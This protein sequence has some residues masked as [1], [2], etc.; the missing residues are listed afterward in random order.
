[1]DRVM[2]RVYNDTIPPICAQDAEVISHIIARQAQLYCQKPADPSPFISTAKHDLVSFM[3]LSDKSYQSVYEYRVKAFQKWRGP[4]G[5]R[6]DKPVFNAVLD[7][8]YTHPTHCSTLPELSSKV[9]MALRWLLAPAR[10]WVESKIKCDGTLSKSDIE[11]ADYLLHPKKHSNPGFRSFSS[12]LRV[13]P[14]IV[15]TAMKGAAISRDHGFMYHP[16]I[17]W[18]R[19]QRQKQRPIFGDSLDNLAW[20]Y[21]DLSWLMFD[22]AKLTKPIAYYPEINIMQEMQ[23]LMS[24]FQHLMSIEGDYEQMDSYTCIDTVLWAYDNICDALDIPRSLRLDG[25]RCLIAYF[26]MPL[27]TGGKKPSVLM[28]EHNLLSGVY[29]TNGMESYINIIHQ[30]L[31]L[32]QI[33]EYRGTS[34]FDLVANSRFWV[35]GDDSMLILPFDDLDHTFAREAFVNIASLI[36][37]VANVSKQR[38]STEAAQFCRFTY[39]LTVE[40]LAHHRQWN[41]MKYPIYIIDMAVNSAAYPESGPL[42]F[43]G[44]LAEE[45]PLLS[46]LDNAVGDPMYEKIVDI[47][48]SD[49]DIRQFLLQ[50]KKLQ[51]SGCRVSSWKESVYGADQWDY[52]S[53][54]TFQYL[55]EK[56]K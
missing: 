15:E 1:M 3:T 49:L 12:K 13:D 35:K 32:E 23:K 54:P 30:L 56:L 52:R 6:C 43:A 36:G 29:V 31:L 16:A 47:L 14:T 46:R 18:Y 24:K 20:G 17:V 48:F 50:V 37:E 51:H 45:L 42:Y 28:A 19:D 38:V 8:F 34:Y 55:K 25:R 26:N 39:P 4:Q 7:T 41:G 27:C 9:K 53:S 5:R 21:R 44:Q 40:A 33:A 11:V 22:C 2:L 10:R